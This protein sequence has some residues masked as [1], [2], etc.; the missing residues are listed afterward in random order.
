[1]PT[2]KPYKEPG[3][4]TLLVRGTLLLLTAI[5]VWGLGAGILRLLAGDTSSLWTW[6]HIYT[7]WPFT[8]S[9]LFGTFA[10]S[11]ELLAEVHGHEQQSDLRLGPLSWF[12]LLF[13]I[14]PVL[15]H[16]L[17]LLAMYW[18][19]PANAERLL[20]LRF[21]IFNWVTYFGILAFGSILWILLMFEVRNLGNQ[22]LRG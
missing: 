17:S 9:A 19:S 22:R 2:R 10:F 20:D 13:F 4:F 7:Y 11:D 12:V 16:A 15:C 18:Q 6:A 3:P 8:F 21:Q 14:S 1:M 5:I